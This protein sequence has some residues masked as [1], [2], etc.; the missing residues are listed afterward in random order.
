[1]KGGSTMKY[2]ITDA[3]ITCGRCEAGCPVGCIS[4]NGYNF[5]IDQTTCIQCGTCYENCPVDAIHA[6]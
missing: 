5:E 1:M 2:V 4:A 6:E 3:C